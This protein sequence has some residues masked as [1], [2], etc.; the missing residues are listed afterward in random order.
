MKMR[1]C[2]ITMLLLLSFAASAYAKNYTYEYTTTP[3]GNTTN[4]TSFQYI[5]EPFL[6]LQF[7]A[8][9]PDDTLSP[10]DTLSTWTDPTG[11][12]YNLSLAT[13]KNGAWLGFPTASWT[14]MR[15]AGNWTVSAWS[16]INQTTYIPRLGTYATVTINY[17]TLKPFEFKVLPVPEPVSC[18]LFLLGGAALAFFRK[19]S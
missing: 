15:V 5:Q 19:K 8:G 14:T 16:A 1:L 13:D 11:K 9:L 7:N 12:T 6:F 18:G 4:I 17:N 3:Y 2:V 10:S